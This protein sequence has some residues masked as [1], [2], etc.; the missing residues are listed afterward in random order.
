MK[1]LLLI[2]IS[3]LILSSPVIGNSHK[4]E[5]LYRWENPSGDGYVW[6]KIGDKETHSLYK[7]DVKNVKPNGFGILIY[8]FG[9][10]YEGKRNGQGT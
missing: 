7:G 6:K 9:G 1:H 2:F 10:K 4:G 8:S 5:T 3:F